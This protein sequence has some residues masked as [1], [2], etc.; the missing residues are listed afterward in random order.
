MIVRLACLP[1]SP[2]GRTGSI[3][4]PSRQAAFYMLPA[5]A[6]AGSVRSNVMELA[7]ELVSIAEYLTNHFCVHERA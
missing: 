3:V 5:S 2:Y 4:C 6:G 1:S 7:G